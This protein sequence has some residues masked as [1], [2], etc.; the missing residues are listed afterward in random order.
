MIL[1]HQPLFRRFP[2]E[3]KPQILQA[4]RLVLFAKVERGNFIVQQATAIFE[5]ARDTIINKISLLEQ[6]KG[7]ISNTII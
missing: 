1:L 3:K 2:Y 5:S 6:G 4:L 7:M